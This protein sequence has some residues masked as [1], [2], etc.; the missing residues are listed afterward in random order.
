MYLMQH[1]ILAPKNTDVDEVNNAILESLFEKLHTYLNANS[2]TL[3]EEGAS[4]VAEF[5]WIHCIRWN[6]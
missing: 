4:V 3:T 6:F 5:Q 2:L 1:N